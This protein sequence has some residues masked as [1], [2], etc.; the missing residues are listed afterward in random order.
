MDEADP[1]DHLMVLREIVGSHALQFTMQK[2]EHT[3]K[4]HR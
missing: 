3:P 1:A 4:E 2:N